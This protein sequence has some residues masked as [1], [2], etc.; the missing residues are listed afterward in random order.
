MTASPWATVAEVRG[1]VHRAK[2]VR[3]R[4]RAAAAPRAEREA[5][6]AEARVAE[7]R[8]HAEEH[9]AHV[10]AADQHGVTWPHGRC[11]HL[12]PLIVFRTV[13]HC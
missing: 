9:A 13:N 8:A 4:G 5:A 7:Q 11:C 3:Q 2:A 12:T 6:G 1:E 10:A